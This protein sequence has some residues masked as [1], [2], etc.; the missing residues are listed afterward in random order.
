MD[1]DDRADPFSATE[2]STCLK[3]LDALGREPG[4]APDPAR[5]E[6]AV[7]RIYKKARR[8]RR[9]ASAEE[10]QATD[11]ATV[12]ATG[13]ARESAEVAHAPPTA[14]RA[15]SRLCYICKG[16]Y[17]EVHAHYH[18]LCPDCAGRNLAERLRRSDL[19]GR[20]AVVT[21]GRIKIGRQVA[22]RLLRDGADVLVTTRFPDDAANRY[23]AEPDFDAW[24][25]RLWIEPL[26]LRRP[27]DVL[28][29][30]A[31]VASRFPAIEILI[32]NAAQS[33]RRIEDDLADAAATGPRPS[34]ALPSSV[35][36]L[37]RHAG[38]GRATIHQGP[39]RRESNS[40]TARID[41]VPP[42]ELLEVLL[43]NA[44]APFWLIAGLR[45]LMA[46]SPF[47]DRYVVNVAGLDGRFAG[48]KSDRHP[49]INM[50]KAGLNMITRTSAADLARDGIY[51][52]SVDAGWVTHEGAYSRRAR[53]RTRGFVPPL[54]EVDAAA[55]VL[56]P[57]ARGLSGDRAWG[58]FFKDFEPADW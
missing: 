54:D 26:D 43:V 34:P 31:R 52:N 11:R 58:G 3:V 44:A 48:G 27:P 12:A 17:R 6:R 30:P 18:L 36:D 2:W 41:E 5:L 33:V 37:L 39:D 28:A 7:A 57:I 24:R 40:W 20:R 42:V 47:E 14:L 25:D 23:A 13:R 9:K 56:D 51:L 29:F 55:R 8:L 19:A 4:L 22:M 38:G 15:R 45:P 1:V 21:G 49:H 46:A 53:M 32:N 16:R 50:S 10:R 35:G